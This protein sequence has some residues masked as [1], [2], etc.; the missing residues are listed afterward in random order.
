MFMRRGL[1]GTL[2]LVALV[3]GFMLLATACGGSGPSQK[4]LDDAK[5]QLGEKDKEIAALKAGAEATPDASAGPALRFL[6]YPGAPIA[7]MGVLGAYGNAPTREPRP[8]ATPVPAGVTPPPPPTPIP[9]PDVTVPFFAYI[10]TVTAGPGESEYNVDPTLSCVKSGLFARGQ[11]IVWRMEAVQ[12][13]TGK[14][15]TDRDAT[16]VLKLPNGEEIKMRYGRHGNPAV[17]GAIAS[18]F[19]TG[20]WTA[21]LDYPLG[22]LEYQI[23]LTTSSGESATFGDPLALRSPNFKG[24]MALDTRLTIVAAEE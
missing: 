12:T 13:S 8:T 1:L 4:E 19:W 2:L 18:W 21:P 6:Q 17:E 14:I 20:A 3:G 10:D 9:A 22:T 7:S 24:D 11:H 5:L 15:L 23:V 16:A